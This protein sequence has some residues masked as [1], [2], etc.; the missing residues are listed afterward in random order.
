MLTTRVGAAFTL[1]FL[2]AVGPAAAGELQAV[3]QVRPG[4]RAATP[5]AAKIVSSLR[6][7]IQEFAAEGVTRGS[8]AGLQLASRYTSFHRRVDDAGRVQVYVTVTDTNPA[9]LAALQQHDLD[10]EIVNDGFALVQGWVPVDQLEALAAEA[11]VRKVAPPS[12]GVTRTGSV[13]SQGDAIHRCSQVRP[14]SGALTGAGSKVGVISDGV[15]GLAASQGTGDLPVSVQVLSAGT[16]DE[17]TAMLEI[18]HDCAP[19]AALAFSS[20]FPTS[21]AFINSVNNLRGAGAQIIVDDLGFFAEPYFEDGPIAT[22]DKTAGALALRVSAA[23]NDRQT[24]YAGTF[25]P[26]P[27]ETEFIGVRHIFGGGDTFLAFRVG[28][29]GT[30]SIILQWGNPFGLSGDDY[31]LCVRQPGGGALVACSLEFQDGNDDPI[32]GVQVSC[33]GPGQCA[34]EIQITRFAGVTRPLKFFCIGS[35]AL[36]EFIVTAGSIFGH[37]AVPEVLA[38][39]AAGAASPTT[40]EPYSS[41]GP[42]N[43][44]FPGAVTRSKPDVTGIDCVSTTRPGFTTFCGTSAAAPH[45]AAIA[46]LARQAKPGA[47]VA[48]LRN[49]LRLSAID[50]GTAGFDTSFGSGRADAVNATLLFVDVHDDNPF[51]LHIEAIAKAGVTAGCAT[52]PALYCPADPVTRGQMAVFLL[53]ADEGPSFAPPPCTSPLFGDVPCSHPFAAWINE[54]ARRNITAGC[55]AGNYCP[56][57][58]VSRQEMAV[59]LIRA[60][61]PGFTPPACG[62]PI[63]GDVPCSSIFAI[64]IHELVSRNVTSGCGNGNYCPTAP[65]TR[66]QMAVFLVRNFGLPFP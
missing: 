51:R 46:A 62:S 53:R 58:S 52:N 61:S 27:P 38:V 42:V 20:G 22:N 21:L 19:G 28:A 13:N 56:Q 17:G 29:G 14:P 44:L 26:G 36:D 11:V 10:V 12:Y 55:G 24:H 65:V 63:F 16:G 50:L 49:I 31:D 57:S 30:A 1:A 25:T 64:W 18:V 48:E 59:F 9:T 39:A 32:E 4:G 33:P 8:T 45:L 2:C 37:P 23:G 54:L 6:G 40:I 43:I 34:G 35:C 66:E 7:L 5:A 47:G 41:A 15:S 60:A 3:G